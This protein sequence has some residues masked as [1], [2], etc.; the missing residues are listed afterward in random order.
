[1]RGASPIAACHGRISTQIWG[2]TIGRYCGHGQMCKYQNMQDGMISQ[3]AV[4]CLQ[5]YPSPDRRVLLKHVSVTPFSN[6][7]WNRMAGAAFD[8]EAAQNVASILIKGTK[9]ICSKHPQ[10]L[11]LLRSSGLQPALKILILKTRL[12]RLVLVRLPLRL[13]TNLIVTRR[14]PLRVVPLL[15]RLQTKLACRSDNDGLR[16]NA[17]PRNSRAGVALARLFS[18]QRTLSHV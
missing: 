3:P 12:F 4:I 11:P 17:F 14:L 10:S 7:S 1:M 15:A 8:I 9:S 6:K 5:S 18:F 16:A 13:P 2:G